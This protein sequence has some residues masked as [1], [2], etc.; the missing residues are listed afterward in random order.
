MADRRARLQ[1]ILDEIEGIR[2]VTEAATFAEFNRSWPMLRATQH[3]LS[4]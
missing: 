3:A 1:N 2:A 4:L